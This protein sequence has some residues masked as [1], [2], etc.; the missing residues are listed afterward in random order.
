MKRL[1]PLILVAALLAG[2]GG[3]GSKTVEG[4]TVP[5]QVSTTDATPAVSQAERL[6]ACLKGRPATPIGAFAGT[7]ELAKSQ[8]GAQFAA[9]VD[10]GLVQLVVFPTAD[11][12]QTGFKDASDRLISLQQ[13]QPAIYN[14]VSAMQSQVLGNVLQLTPYGPIPATAA[15]TVT[16]CIQRTAAP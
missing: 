9:R 1:A 7:A 15:Q 8:G 16:G 10:G 13:T 4:T 5:P 14:Q 6:R 12:A 11:A 2:C 3:G